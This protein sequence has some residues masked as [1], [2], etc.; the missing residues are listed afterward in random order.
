MSDSVLKILCVR[1]VVTTHCKKSNLARL[2]G[3]EWRHVMNFLKLI[4]H[5][6]KWKGTNVHVHAYIYTQTYSMVI[7]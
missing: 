1:H 4:I 3:F 5:L 7:P 6:K 2:S